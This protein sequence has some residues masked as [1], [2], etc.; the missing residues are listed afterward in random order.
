MKAS[1]SSRDEQTIIKPSH[2]AG[3]H[4]LGHSLWLMAIPLLSVGLFSAVRVIALG[5]LS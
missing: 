3:I 2:V 4:Q 1:H 5:A